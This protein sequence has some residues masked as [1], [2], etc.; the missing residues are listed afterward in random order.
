[1]WNFYLKFAF[2]HEHSIVIEKDYEIKSVLTHKGIISSQSLKN[3]V[4][5]KITAIE[6]LV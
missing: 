1:M 2:K 3:K 6:M 4:K 5:L